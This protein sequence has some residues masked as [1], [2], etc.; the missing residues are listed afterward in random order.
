MRRERRGEE[1]ACQKA[2]DFLAFRILPPSFSNE[3]ATSLP[4]GGCFM[5]APH[6]RRGGNLHFIETGRRGRR[7]L[8]SKIITLLYTTMVCNSVL[9][10]NNVYNSAL[11]RR[12]R[13]LSQKAVGVPRYRKHYRDVF[14]Y[15]TPEKITP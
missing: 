10:S 6:Y 4:E 14:C 13:L 5:G 15:R 1:N 9:V 7:P 3:N 11:R 2:C 12:G 8:P